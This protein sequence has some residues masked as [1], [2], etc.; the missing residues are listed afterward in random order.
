MFSFSAPETRTGIPHTLRWQYKLVFSFENQQRY[1]GKP[2]RH[3]Q[4]THT[5]ATIWRAWLRTFSPISHKRSPGLC[6]YKCP[7]TWTSVW[8]WTWPCFVGHFHITEFCD[9]GHKILLDQILDHWL[10]S[11]CWFSGRK[12]RS[13]R[14]YHCMSSRMATHLRTNPAQKFPDKLFRI[15]AGYVFWLSVQS[16]CQR[17]RD[18][19][20]L[21]LE[22]QVFRRLQVFVRAQQ[23]LEIVHDK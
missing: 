11:F 9:V 18:K 8:S 21:V 4:T 3:S 1:D 19:H 5:E 6:N 23:R 12:S 15:V 22:P 14:M 10:I 7:K 2:C 13:S 16:V 17:N 20:V